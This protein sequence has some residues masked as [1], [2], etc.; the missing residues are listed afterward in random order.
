MKKPEVVAKAAEGGCP[1]PAFTKLYPTLAEY[2]GDDR[3]EDG[4][5]RERSSLQVKV[6]DGMI[7]AVLQDHDLSRGLYV[8]GESVT[9][10]LRSLEKHAKDPAADWRAWKAYKGK[11]K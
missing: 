6:Q 11:R 1:D 3:W 4:T 9:E 8:V 2:I 5:P 10:A 7:L